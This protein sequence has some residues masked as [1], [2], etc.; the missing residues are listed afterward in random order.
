MMVID[1]VHSSVVTHMHA[2]PTVWMKLARP[3]H[4]LEV[5]EAARSIPNGPSTVEDK[6]TIT[7]NLDPKPSTSVIRRRIMVP[8]LD[9]A[10]DAGFEQ[11][12]L[13][14]SISTFTAPTPSPDHSHA[15]KMDRATKHLDDI[16]GRYVL[17]MALQPC[18][19]CS[20]VIRPSLT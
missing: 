11:L 1:T 2:G 6:G 18:G 19:A 8:Q 15:M 7:D 5:S 9:E 17:R 4:S 16:Y 3:L 13:A 12:Q 20:S 14:L 10:D